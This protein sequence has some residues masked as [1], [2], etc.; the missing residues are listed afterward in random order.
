MD[1]S[2]LLVAG[3]FAA[4]TIY[5][6]GPPDRA[7]SWAQG[8]IIASLFTAVA[9]EIV[10]LKRVAYGTALADKVKDRLAEDLWTAAQY[11]GTRVLDSLAHAIERMTDIESWDEHKNKDTPPTIQA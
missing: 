1:T 3:T 2:T 8:A 10:R 4:T 7:R 5:L 9:N 11:H 6:F